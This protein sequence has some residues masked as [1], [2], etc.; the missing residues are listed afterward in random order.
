MPCVIKVLRA[1]TN[2]EGDGACNTDNIGN[3]IQQQNT[4]NQNVLAD[5]SVTACGQ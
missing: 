5:L 1:T 3:I 2:V 4:H